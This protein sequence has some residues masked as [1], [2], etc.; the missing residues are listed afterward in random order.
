[1]QKAE[2]KQHGQD[3]GRSDLGVLRD[4]QHLAAVAAV[5][6]DAADQRKQNDRRLS[7][8]G[9]EA[10]IER[11]LRESVNQPGLGHRLHPTADARSAGAQPE[12][13]EI[14]IG[15]GLEDAIAKRGETRW[16][17]DSGL[18][19]RR[20]LPVRAAGSGRAGAGDTR[21][22]HMRTVA[23]LY[24]GSGFSLWMRC[25]RLPSQSVKNTSRLPELT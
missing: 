11:V 22:C 21:F 17:R 5:G 7:E 18:R 9:V 1:M 20:I 12:Q 19:H 23:R 15:E 6:D 4:E 25:T 10:Q 3:A 13:A 8:E 24:Q 2:I 14:A 16:R